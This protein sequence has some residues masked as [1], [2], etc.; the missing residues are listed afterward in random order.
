MIK[1]VLVAE[2]EAALRML[3][4]HAFRKAGFEPVIVGSAK[5]AVD[6]AHEENFGCI[7]LDI[8]MPGMDG[9][10]GMQRIDRQYYL[11]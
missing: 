8:K 11:R 1:R 5:E 6:K 9:I 3:Y 4:E 10:E 7:V 2:D